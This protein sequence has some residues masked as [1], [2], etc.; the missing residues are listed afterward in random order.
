MGKISLA[1]GLHFLFVHFGNGLMFH[2]NITT[3]RNAAAIFG[4][5][6]ARVVLALG[7]VAGATN[8]SATAD[9]K[10][11]ELIDARS[12]SIPLNE[13][14]PHASAILHLW[15]TWCGPCRKEL[16][17]VE[18]FA[19]EL[20]RERLEDRLVVVSTDKGPFE[21]VALF[22]DDLGLERLHSWQVHHGHLGNVFQ[23][24]GYPTTLLLD[25][26]GNVI[27]RR[28]GSLEWDDDAVRAAL[29]KHLGIAG[30]ATPADR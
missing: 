10:S 19:D 18:R 8:S 24:L 14:L 23:V 25:A 6:V 26:E 5:T 21:Q 17:G 27:E 4:D 12:R 2:S 28:T 11:I 20:A 1:A 22:L 29:F 16:P 13:V 15:A 3:A 7:L 30:A 9:I